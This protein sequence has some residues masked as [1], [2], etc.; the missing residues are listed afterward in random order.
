MSWFRNLAE[1]YERCKNIV[2]IPDEKENIL[3]PPNHTVKRHTSLCVTVNENGKFCFCDHSKLTI[4]IPCTEKSKTGRTSGTAPH[5]L[6]EELSYLALN[7]KRRSAYLG[8]LKLWKHHHKKVE[9]VYKYVAG[10]TLIDDLTAC[11]IKTD[12]PKLFI[13]FSVKGIPDDPTPNLWKDESVAKAWQRFCME[14]EQAEKTL[15]YV[16]GGNSFVSK[17]HPKGFFPYCK[18]AKLISFNDTQNY[19][20]RG[21]FS[22]ARETNAIGLE[23]SH[24]AHAMLEYLIAKQRNTCDTQAIIAWAVDDGSAAPNLF[25][26]REQLYRE[27][28]LFDATEA[29]DRDKLIVAWGEI[30][31]NYAKNLRRALT[32]KDNAKQL[33]GDARQIAV[34][35]INS[36]TKDSGRMAVTFYKDLPENEYIDRIVRWHETCCWYFWGKNGEYISAPSSDRLIAAVYGEPKDKDYSKIKKQSRE[37]ILSFILNGVT[38]DKSWLTAAVNRVSNPFSYSKD[39]RWDKNK[40][41]SAINVTCAIARKYYSDKEREVFDLELNKTQTNRDYLYGRLLAVADIFEMKELEKKEKGKDKKETRPTNAVRYM[42]AFANR[43]YR[44]WLQIRKIISYLFVQNKVL[45]EQYQRQI[46]E[47]MLLFKDGEYESNAPLNGKYLM[48]Y[49]LQRR[50]LE[51]I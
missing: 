51:K 13:R 40:W 44:M 24:K 11:E 1:T 8:Q 38:L 19:S 17:L 18:N 41:E 26:D 29:T 39:K 27:F 37:R 2:G 21:R 32:G 35:A 46:D 15:C 42:S 10:N 50:E 6:H 16:T 28:G 7:E 43:P 4:P 12:D 22:K 36:T 3:L 30:D 49:S 45:G 47:I 33:K 23:T 5:P 25:A 20:F 9:A 14:T 31:Y 34:L 48:G